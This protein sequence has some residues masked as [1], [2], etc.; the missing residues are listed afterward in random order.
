M[1]DLHSV[2]F[3]FPPNLRVLAVR[4]ALNTTLS[5]VDHFVVVFAAELVTGIGCGFSTAPVEGVSI[6][7]GVDG[8]GRVISV[9]STW[10]A[11]TGFEYHPFLTDAGQQVANSKGIAWPERPELPSIIPAAGLAPAGAPEAGPPSKEPLTLAYVVAAL[12][13]G[14]RAWVPFHISPIG[15]APLPAADVPVASL[16]WEPSYR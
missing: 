15:D 4:P 6:Q 5:D 1:R 12:S 10:L 11:Y 14:G 2:C 16:S 8:A 13:R 3:L 9:R 7:V